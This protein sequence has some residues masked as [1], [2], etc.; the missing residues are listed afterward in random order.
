[1]PRSERART[2]PRW[3]RPGRGV[4]YVATSAF[5]FSIM[6]AFVKAAGERIPS[7]EIVAAR[8]VVSLVLS[9]ALLRHAG[10]SPWGTRRK[11]LLLRGFLGYLALACVFH[12]VTALP[13]ADATVIQYLYPAFTAVLATLL[14]GERPTPAIV[15]SG[16]A[17]LVGVMMVAQPSAV[18]GHGAAPLDARDVSIAVLGALLTAMAYVVVKKLSPDEHPL[19]IVFYFPL[20]TLPATFPFL[21]TSAVMPQGREWLYLLGVG[22]ATQFGQVLLT[23]GLQYETATR[24]TALT[25]LQVVFATLWGVTF[26]GEVPGA[27]TVA[28]AALVVG[29]SLALAFGRA[30]QATPRTG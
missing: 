26:F 6:T 7:Q 12:A 16:V 17:G 15:V 18:F 5:A 30:D 10:L 19:V 1:M 3:Q 22:L 24:A 29:S 23:R 13:L 20:V 21:W 28:G 11:L 2:P 8:A 4:A 27:W 9:W 14:L 25:Y